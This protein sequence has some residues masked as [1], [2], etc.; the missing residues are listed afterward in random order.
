M[1]VGGDIVV[2]PKSEVRCVSK[3]SCVR[4]LSEDRGYESDIEL[5]IWVPQWSIYAGVSYSG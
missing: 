4:V 2:I 5:R 3:A 1:F